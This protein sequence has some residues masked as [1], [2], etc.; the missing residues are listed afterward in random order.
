MPLYEF[1]CDACGPFQELRPMQAA[2]EPARCPVCQSTALRVFTPPNLYRTSPA[3]RKVRSREEQSA[4]EPEVVV[5][6]PTGA[7]ANPRPAPV[8]SRHPWA[9]GP[10][11]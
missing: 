7:G 6:Q 4:H 10:G 2:S 8:V 11:T 3:Y 5:R 9:V 1:R